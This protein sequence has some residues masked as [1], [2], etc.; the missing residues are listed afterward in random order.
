MTIREAMREPMS[1]QAL[2]CLVIGIGLGIAFSLAN[3]VMLG[4]LM[5]TQSR[6]ACPPAVEQAR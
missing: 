6:P 3:V 2:V 5:A 1:L 4:S